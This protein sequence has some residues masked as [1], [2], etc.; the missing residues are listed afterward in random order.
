MQNFLLKHHVYAQKI[1]VGVSGGADSLALV[2]MAA[3]Q[4]NVFGYKIIALTVNHK[5][6]KHSDKEAEYVAS[7]MQ[8]HNIEH[9]ILVWKGKKPQNSIE[10]AARH[11]RYGLI[12][13]W[14]KNHDVKYL[15]TAH[16][17]KDQAETFLMRLQ[18][19]SGAEG[20][21]AMREQSQ[22]CDNLVILRPFLHTNP[23]KLK[24]YLQNKNIQWIEDESNKNEK[25]LRVRMR[26]FL[27]QF[28]QKTGINLEK[29]DE[30]IT[31]LQSTEDFVEQYVQNIL[32]EQVKIDNYSIAD[33]DYGKFL[34]WHP[35]IQYRIMSHLCR[36]NYCPRSESV[37][38]LLKKMR[39]LPFDGTTLG[40]RAIF[41]A[42]AKIWVVPET[43]TKH[44][45]SRKKWQ[46]FV[47]KNPEYKNIKIPHK[48]KI[49]ILESID[50]GV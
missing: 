32:H 12:E 4:L 1:A 47:E 49:W 17:L 48:A 7:L 42:Y 5:L 20:L 11:A 19:G 43:T 22:W 40:G 37:L 36:K 34:Q 45:Q 38:G 8:K 27:P 15:M 10:E 9:H 26:K 41:L 30:A 25:F 46:Q 3:E 21:C 18:R 23:Q 14:C 6:R 50:H 44:K 13:E 28:M 29:F 39:S 31:N 16:H 2:L 35:E 24:D 33:F